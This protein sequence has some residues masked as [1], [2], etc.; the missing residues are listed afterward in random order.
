MAPTPA[1]LADQIGRLPGRA[2]KW[3]RHRTEPFARPLDPLRASSWQALTK[4]TNVRTSRSHLNIADRGRFRAS[5]PIG[6]ASTEGRCSD[7]SDLPL[8]RWRCRLGPRPGIFRDQRYFET[9]TARPTLGCRFI[10]RGIDDHSVK[11]DAN[12]GGCVLHAL[13]E[14]QDC[15]ALV[16]I[17][18][19]SFLQRSVSSHSRSRLKY[20]EE[21]QFQLSPRKVSL[22][23]GSAPLP[24]KQ[25]RFGDSCG[26]ARSISGRGSAG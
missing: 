19:C 3:D 18:H 25:D 15:K 16:C 21:R 24:G 7:S 26:I 4:C 23:L 11:V 14:L 17:L 5:G 10:L 8:R 6:T 9:R 20:S 1:L 22:R 13:D 2:R 12:A